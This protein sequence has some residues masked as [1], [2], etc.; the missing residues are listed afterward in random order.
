MA[1]ALLK[2]FPEGYT[3]LPL[4]MKY[5]GSISKGTRNVTD[6]IFDKRR[7]REMIPLE[8]S[9]YFQMQEDL[10]VFPKGTLGRYQKYISAG[11]ERNRKL[12]VRLSKLTGIPFDKGHIYGLFNKIGEG[13]GSHDP[14]AQIAELLSENRGKGLDNIPKELAAS[15]D[16]PPNWQQSALEFVHRDTGGLSGSQLPVDKVTGKT[17]SDADL[18]KV[19]RLD[20]SPDQVV[21]NKWKQIHDAI[22]EAELAKANNTIPQYLN[23]I[24]SRIDKS[25]KYI[26]TFGTGK[27]N[28]KGEILSVGNKLDMTGKYLRR[29]LLTNAAY[30]F[31][32]PRSIR[33]AS[34]IIAEGPNKENIKEVGLG[35]RDDLIHTGVIK[36]LG[37]ATNAKALS[38]GGTVGAVPLG[39]GLVGGMAL[40]SIVEGATGKNLKETGEQAEEKKLY[41][42]YH[43]LTNKKSDRQN[44]RHST[45][46]EVT[47]EMLEEWDTEI[48]QG[49]YED[50]LED[51]Q[52]NSPLKETGKYLTTAQ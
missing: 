42:E 27:P 51:R 40:N 5:K 6:V 30:S 3:G 39:V 7:F 19:T 24:S 18:G 34:N 45:S 52:L 46:P 21:A 35:V 36:G 9:K 48:R 1:E 50:S 8:V 29:A 25:G 11:N 41:R 13:G 31:I 47:Q 44:Y 10:G 12:A 17:L 2:L 16:V 33:A 28:V 23:N 49:W 4:E 22:T 43:G 32:N 38:I 15:L 37:V 26:Q 20:F 14:A